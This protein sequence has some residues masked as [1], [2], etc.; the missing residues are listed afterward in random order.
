[1]PS[2]IV[3]ANAI[4][5]IYNYSLDWHDLPKAKAVGLMM[6]SSNG[7][8]IPRRAGEI[9]EEMVYGCGLTV[10]MATNGDVK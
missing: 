5:A 1:M 3:E 6:Q 2:I 7:V 10:I 8:M 9:F 4:L